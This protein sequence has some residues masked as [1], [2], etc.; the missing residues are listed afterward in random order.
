M[1]AT[2]PPDAGKLAH[3]SFSAF[4]SDG[5]VLRDGVIYHCIPRKQFNEA[6]KLGWLP[7]GSCGVRD[8]GPVD[9]FAWMC[10]C[11]MAVPP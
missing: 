3:A 5:G 9:L 11:T 7:L 1:T 8:E 4:C 10:R 6:L 2:F